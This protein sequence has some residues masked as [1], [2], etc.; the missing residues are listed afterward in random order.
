MERRSIEQVLRGNLLN[1]ASSISLSSARAIW[2][3]LVTV[4]AMS[5][6]GIM[7]T[8]TEALAA[9]GACAPD[10]NGTPAAA[11]PIESCSGDFAAG[12]SYPAAI[13]TAGS[14]E[15]DLNSI[16]NTT[17]GGVIV[18]SGG[19]VNLTVTQV[20][21][22]GN[23]TNLAGTGIA[24]TSLGG[25]V[26]ITTIGGNVTASSVPAGTYT[27]V[28]GLPVA[29][30]LTSLIKKL[31]FGVGSMDPLTFVSIPALL[32]VAALVA[33]YVPARRAAKVDP[34]V[35]LRGE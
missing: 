33:C 11:G 32:A 7:F 28:I 13:G 2:L 6:V 23:I 24:V 27:T 14:F 9:A 31:L 1:S 17:T 26:S 29:I 15:V 30:A 16:T 18:S 3:P 20:T 19:A 12:I 21:T 25:N 22:P 10:A 35:A 4:A 34:V 8:P 5:L